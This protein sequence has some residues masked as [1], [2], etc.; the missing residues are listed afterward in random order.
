MTGVL[1]DKCDGAKVIMQDMNG[2]SERRKVWVGMANSGNFY[3]YDSTNN[4]AIVDCPAN[5]SSVA[6]NGTSIPSNATLITTSKLKTA[7]ITCSFY[8]D[9]WS[10]SFVGKYWSSVRTVADDCAKILAITIQDF[11]N[12]SADA[13]VIPM[14]AS[15]TTFNFMS[16]IPKASMRQDIMLIVRVLYLA[17]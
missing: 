16:N 7:D 13:V 6:V 17:S 3:I 10:Q 5:G 2:S 12:M 8:N 1:T 14:I 11:G 9:A 4:K 15:N